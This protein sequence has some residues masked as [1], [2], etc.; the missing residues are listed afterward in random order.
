MNRTI[1][2]AACVCAAALAG[3]GRTYVREEKVV[4]RPVYTPAPAV[5][6]ASPQAC[7]YGG[8]LYATGSMSCQ[9][10]YEYTCSNGVWERIPGS[11][12]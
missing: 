4:E 10:T 9:G 7:T 3:C 6:I 8:N 11:T 2:V 12:C 1:L 5:A